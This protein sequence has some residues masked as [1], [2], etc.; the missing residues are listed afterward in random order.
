MDIY[1]QISAVV[2]QHNAWD[3]AGG[4]ECHCGA[5][6]DAPINPATGQWSDHLAKQIGDLVIG[7]AG[8][9]QLT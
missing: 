3:Y 9:G 1:Q 4:L 5:K 2:D 6:F 7:L 8:T